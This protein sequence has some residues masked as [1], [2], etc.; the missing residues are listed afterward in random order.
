MDAE[1]IMGSLS[2][3][4]LSFVSTTLVHDSNYEI[5][6]AMIKHYPKL[7]ELSIGEIADLCYTSKASISRFCRF[8]GWT[9]S[10]SFRSAWI[11][12]SPCGQT[13]P[14]NSMLCFTAT[15]RWPSAPIG[16]H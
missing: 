2:D 12:T 6:L 9:A 1:K 15:R 14:G 3:R 16:M 5:A 7:K 10:R 8:L 4:L 13:I 11:R